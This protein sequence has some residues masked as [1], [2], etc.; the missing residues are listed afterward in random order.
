MHVKFELGETLKFVD[1]HRN[2]AKA[3][4]MKIKICGDSVRKTN[5]D[6]IKFPGDNKYFCSC[7]KHGTLSPVLSNLDEHAS[8][9][10]NDIFQR[11]RRL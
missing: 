8:Q 11:R 10:F 9:C 5:D 2:N 7:D 3:R 1:E 4:K 6:Q